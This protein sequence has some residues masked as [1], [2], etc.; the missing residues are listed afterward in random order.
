MAKRLLMSILVLSL[1]LFGCSQ[2][3]LDEDVF[4]DNTKTYLSK[5]TSECA[6]IRFKCDPGMAP[7]SDETGCGCEPVS[8]ENNKQG[9][10]TYCLDEQRNADACIEIYQPVC[11]YFNKNIQC[12][13]YPCAMN[14]EN[15]CKACSNED[16][17]YFEQ[18]VCPK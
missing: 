18:G 16:V 4:V 8:E 10:R 14:F 17:D 12:I 2:M 9:E 13:K 11:G 5:N 6:S 3:N 15:S 1:F 7:F